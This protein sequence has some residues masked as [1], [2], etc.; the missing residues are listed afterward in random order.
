MTLPADS[1]RLVIDASVGFVL[2]LAYFGGLWWTVART[3]TGRSGVW[4]LPASS[5]MRTALLLG[6]FWYVSQGRASCLVACVAGWW[7]AR[8]VMIRRLGPAEKANAKG[9]SPCT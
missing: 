1:Y 6:G 5:L 9:G 2:G 8:Q 7:G 4:L 3:T